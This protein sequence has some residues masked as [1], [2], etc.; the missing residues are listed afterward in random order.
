[1]EI[2]ALYTSPDSLE[3]SLS[4]GA[5]HLAAS[6]EG[7]AL[8]YRLSSRPDEPDG[9]AGFTCAGD[10]QQAGNALEDFRR[11]VEFSP[12][13][14]RREAPGEPG[15]I[16]QRAAG[17]VFGFPVRRA[18][19]ALGVALVGCPGAWPRV[20]NAEV[21]S[22]LQQIALVLEHHE[23]TTSGGKDEPPEDLLRLSEQLLEQDL[24]LIKQEERISEVEQLKNDLIERMSHELRAPLNGIIER[25]ISVLASEHESLSES[26][27]ASLRGAL[28]DGN[29][30][31]R[32]LQNTLDLW[33]LRQNE[34]RVERHDVN[35]AEVTEE[36]VFNIRDSLKPGVE[37][38]KR[39]PPSL[40]KVRTDLGKLNQI[41]FHVLDN[42]AK[43][44]PN[45]K[46]ELE[47]LLE[48]GQLLCNVTD[49]GIG[50]APDDQPRV[51]EEFFQVDASP[52]NG[53]TG[54]GLGLTLA[55][56]LVE[57][58]GGAISLTSEIGQGTRVSF[59]LP[60]QP[61]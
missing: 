23:M 38:E 33:R 53:Y 36:A 6:V 57:L 49:S 59:M 20:R 7:F 17:G 46:I 31:M 22:V 50:I 45:G 43:F 44:T 39:L 28:D 19:R 13:T 61:V 14:L 12:R 21:D 5:R 51:F 37:L 16:W 58:L 9:W 60:V 48:E 1:V 26:G 4:A 41:M 52:D 18:D 35:L 15:R 47:L 29:A 42:A 25:I 30:L 27:R 54:A 56:A 55:R 24:R 10:A 8:I 11:E 34:V 32:T 3:A 2:L 40:P